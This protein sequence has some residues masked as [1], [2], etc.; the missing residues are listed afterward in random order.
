[1]TDVTLHDKV[2]LDALP[3]LT[4]AFGIG[5]VLEH[6]FLAE[7][8]MN[9]NWR[10]DTGQ[11]SYAIRQ[12]TDVPV[13]KVRRNLGV[14]PHL[15]ADGLPVP[16][17]LTTTDGATVVEIDGHSYCLLPWV[18]GT[19]I[20]GTGLTL[21]QARDLGALLARLHQSLE[22]HAPS[23]V[24]EQDRI[25]KVTGA[26]VARERADRLLGLIPDEGGDAF[27]RAAAEALVERKAVLAAH[28][29][30]QPSVR[31]AAGRHG[32]THGDFQY[33][34]LLRSGDEVTAILDWD[35]LAV[36]PYA[37]EVARTAQVQFGVNGRFD[38]DRVAAFV[39][40]YR[41]YIPLVEGELADGVER[42][43]WKRMTDFWQLEFHY[44]RGDT[45]CDDL[46]LADEELLRW[47]TG[48]RA[49]VQTAFRAA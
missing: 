32:W 49:E 31:M 23:E 46:F 36:R 11:R 13:A 47:W 35:R 39:A 17:A 14:L 8:S 5:E 38:L 2:L 16:V 33:R 7:G 10:I 40:G 25:V 18:D 20:Q 3:A 34:N 4:A 19:H 43:W 42:L 1:M 15:A 27:D 48:H 41:S 21:A 24:P 22:R 29:D 9:R 37:E 26:D 45:S 28:T 6:R 12:I 30:Q 44:D